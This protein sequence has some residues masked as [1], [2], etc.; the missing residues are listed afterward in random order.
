MKVHTVELNKFK[1]AS[2]SVNGLVVFKVDAT[3]TP[4]EPLEGIEPSTILTM[5]EANA[6]V[7]M[8]LL[9]TQLAEFDN[10]KPKSRHGRHG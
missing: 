10:K 1:S 7:L 3:V 4:K 6:R 2:N 9:K 8:Q 5:T